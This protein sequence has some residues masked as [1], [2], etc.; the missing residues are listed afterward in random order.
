MGKIWKVLHRRNEVTKKVHN[1]F[2]NLYENLEEAK[3]P[4]QREKSI[5]GL[6]HGVGKL[7]AKQNKGAFWDDENILYIDLAGG[8]VVG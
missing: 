1:V 3:I 5:F 4:I 2:L 8:Y 6:R 7:A